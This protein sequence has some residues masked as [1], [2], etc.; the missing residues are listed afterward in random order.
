VQ[1]ARYELRAFRQLARELQGYV[2]RCYFSFVV[3]YGKVVRNF[4]EF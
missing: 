2:E 1:P 4:A 3:N